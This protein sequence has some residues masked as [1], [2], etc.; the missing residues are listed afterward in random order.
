MRRIADMTSTM[1]IERLL[2]RN[3]MPGGN[4]TSFKNCVVSPSGRTVS[5]V[6]SRGKNNRGALGQYTKLP[7]IYSAYLKLLVV[8]PPRTSSEAGDGN[9]S[10]DEDSTMDTIDL[11]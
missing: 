3:M 1:T 6:N 10:S 11:D 8:N 9:N 2:Q 7:V 4:V 5:T